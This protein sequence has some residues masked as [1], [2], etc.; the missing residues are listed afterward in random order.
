M[1]GHGVRLDQTGFRLCPR[2]CGSEPGSDSLNF[3]FLFVKQNN[4]PLP[5][6]CF[7]V[8]GKNKW[9]NVSKKHF[10]NTWILCKGKDQSCDLARFLLVAPKFLD[11]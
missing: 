6:S 7:Q 8:G 4:E 9:N 10:M 2:D 1:Q 3:G 5:S 11:L